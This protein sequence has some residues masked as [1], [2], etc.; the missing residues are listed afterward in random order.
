RSSRMPSY[1][2][3]LIIPNCDHN[4]FEE[5]ALANPNS[6]YRMN[7]IQGQLEIMPPQPVRNETDQGELLI[8]YQIVGWCLANANLV[9]HHGG[10]QGAYTL[11]SGDILGPGA[12]VVLSARWNALSTNDR[13]R[14]FPPV[15]P[16]FIVELR[17]ISNSPQ[18]V[19]RKTLLWIGAGEGVSI[20]PIANPPTVRVY[21]YNSNTNSVIWQEFV[22]PQTVTSQVLTGFVMNMQ[23]GAKNERCSS[24]QSLPAETV[25]VAIVICSDSFLPVYTIRDRVSTKENKILV[26]ISSRDILIEVL[27]RE[28]RYSN[29]NYLG[30][31]EIPSDFLS[32]IDTNIIIKD[33]PKSTSKSNYENGLFIEKSNNKRL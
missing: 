18:Y 9:G 25:T 12:S 5:I 29:T 14:A 7:L 8:I 28:A 11:N 13:R 23:E 30:L 15:A 1:L 31:T 2:P 32:L 33:C 6:F 4:L 20:D 21:S 10:S 17:S 19:H 16:N 22:N 26:D 27:I 3:Q 24:D